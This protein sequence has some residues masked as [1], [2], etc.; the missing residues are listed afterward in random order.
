MRRALFTACGLVLLAGTAHAADKLVPS[1]MKIDAGEK[2][3]AMEIVAGW[4]PE[5]SNLNFNGYHDGQMTVI[6]PVGWKVSIHFTNKDGDLPHSILVTKPYGEGSFPQE[7]G[8][9]QVAIPRA[10]SRAPETGI[11]AGQDDTIDF[12]AKEP[13]AFYLYCGA[14]GHGQGGMWDHLEVSAD[15]TEPYVTLADGVSDGFR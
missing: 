10:Y 3:V 12:T 14:A 11:D 2:S 9:D 1:W 7:A 5:N 15:A 8:Q 6:I 4:N 13:G